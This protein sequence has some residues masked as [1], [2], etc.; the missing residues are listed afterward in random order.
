V[1]LLD[2]GELLADLGELDMASPRTITD[3]LV[4]AK[5]NYPADRTV[6]VLWNHGNGWD[7]GDGPSQAAPAVVTRSLLYDD[8]N[9]SKFL[10]NHKVK[11][12]VQAA[13]IKLDMLGL[14]A[15]IMGTIEALYEFKDLAPVIVSSQEVGESHGWDY[16]AVLGALVSNPG[17][18]VEDLAGTIVAAYRNYFEN[19]LYPQDPNY[20]R[21]H[22]IAAFRTLAEVSYAA[23]NTRIGD[24][25]AK[26]ALALTPKD[27]RA[28]L[29]QNLDQ[30]KQLGTSRVQQSKSGG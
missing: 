16:A 18:S 4:W 6:L 19:V 23:G 5:E 7:Q 10:P 25:A 30:A 13:G 20:D 8:D 15:S 21:R 27:F 9:G 24:L 11:Q 14:D 28:S 29:K 1:V 3:F 12:A 17:M 26:K 22:T 2:V